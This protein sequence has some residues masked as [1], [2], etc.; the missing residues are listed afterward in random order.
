MN[1]VNERVEHVKFGAGLITEVKEDIILVQFHENDEVKAF[2]YPEAFEKFLK[3]I[4]TEVQNFALDKLR[5]KREQLELEM[6][7]RRKEF[8]E[9]ELEKQ[10]L[11][12]TP[13][14]KGFSAKNKK[15][16]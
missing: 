9:A 6:E 12:P 8:E 11:K 13:V 3:A 5:L 14:K 7:K 10:K 1:I 16:K 2:Q 4:N 15:K